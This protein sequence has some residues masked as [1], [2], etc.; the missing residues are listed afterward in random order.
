[1]DFN[2]DQTPDNELDLSLPTTIYTPQDIQ[3]NAWTSLAFAPGELRDLSLFLEMPPLQT[4][5]WSLETF[6][7]IYDGPHVHEDGHMDNAISPPVY[8]VYS[9][10]RDGTWENGLQAIED[11]DWSV[12]EEVEDVK[13]T[14]EVSETVPIS[15]AVSEAVEDIREAPEVAETVPISHAER[16]HANTPDGHSTDRPD[17]QQATHQ[18]LQQLTNEDARDAMIATPHLL[19]HPGVPLEVG[20]VEE[21]PTLQDTFTEPEAKPAATSEQESSQD[22]DIVDAEALDQSTPARSP[23]VL[24]SPWPAPDLAIDEPVLLSIKDA[25]LAPADPAR[26]SDDLPTSTN[27]LEEV[28]D[29]TPVARSTASRTP[30]PPLK[31]FLPASPSPTPTNIGEDLSQVASDPPIWETQLQEAAAEASPMGLSDPFPPGAREQSEGADGGEQ[32]LS[33]KADDNDTDVQSDA[34]PSVLS[35]ND[36]S[37]ADRNASPHS[38]GR[39][40]APIAS[41]EERFVD[42]SPP[43][44]ADTD[45]RKRT[46]PVFARESSDTEADAPEKKKIK[47]RS[48]TPDTKAEA[49]DTTAV[50]P[51]LGSIAVSSK[52]PRRNARKSV[53]ESAREMVDDVE[54]HEQQR[55]VSHIPASC[56]SCNCQLTSHSSHPPNSANSLLDPRPQK[57]TSKKK[58]DPPPPPPPPTMT[59]PNPTSTT[60]KRSTSA[61]YTTP[62]RLHIPALHA[63]QFLTANSKPSAPLS[64]PV[65]TSACNSHSTSSACARRLRLC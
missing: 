58:P 60:P 41:E 12:P 5:D 37:I 50:P 61:T 27:A 34:L 44:V 64:L 33:L 39:A 54:E 8:H 14:P 51:G 45:T 35:M 24:A 28:A 63:P 9:P 6:G 3:E 48:E 2:F 49:A 22:I 46:K 47:T 18:Q 36:I 20:H 26:S 11:F 21:E 17:E 31:P 53:K 55:A 7:D 1:M 13:T 52:K 32:Q 56:S 29:D 38:Q 15:R 25:E 10:P 30:L 65:C 42:V 40:L 57:S 23:P 16:P 59:S 43:L 19:K 4:G 62:L